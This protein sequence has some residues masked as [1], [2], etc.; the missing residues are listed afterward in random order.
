MA[1]NKI[2]LALGT[3]LLVAFSGTA[4]PSSPPPRLLELSKLPLFLSGVVVPN[5]FITM[6]DSAS[7]KSAYI[8]GS[9]DSRTQMAFAGGNSTT[10]PVVYRCGWQI[11]RMWSP[12]TNAMYYDPNRRY[13]PPLK[14]DGTPFPN[15]DFNAAWIDG[16]SANTGGRID[17]SHVVDLER[18]YHPTLELGIARS[19]WYALR[20][21][22]RVV[23][24]DNFVDNTSTSVTSSQCSF[25]DPEGPGQTGGAVTGPGNT[26]PATPGETKPPRFRHPNIHTNPDGTREYRPFYYRYSPTYSHS[27]SNVIRERVTANYH[28]CT[29][30]DTGAPCITSPTAPA[31][32]RQNFANWYSYYRV[33]HLAM[34]SALSF[35]FAQNVAGVRMAWQVQED[36]RDPRDYGPDAWIQ[37][38]QTVMRSFDDEQTKQ[39]FFNFLFSFRLLGQTPTRAATV[40]VGEFVKETGIYEDNRNPF[41]DDKADK[42]LSCRANYHLIVTDGYWNEPSISM[43]VQHDRSDLGSLPLPEGWSGG[44]Y[45]AYSYGPSN[46]GLEHRIYWNEPSTGGERPTLADLAFHYWSTDLRLDLPNNVP[47]RWS[48]LSTGVT[49]SATAPVTG[50]EAVAVPEVFFNPK[51]N[52]ARHQHLITFAIAF[53]EST[54]TLTWPDS[55]L[56]LRKGNKTWPSVSNSST[57]GI[58]DLWH[59]T[60]NSRGGYFSAA[61][62][63]GLQDGLGQFLDVVYEQRGVS[64]AATVSSGIATSR[65]LAFRAG[66]D[67]TDWSGFVEA[68]RYKSDGTLQTPAVWRAQDKL[69]DGDP[70][71]GERVIITS[72]NADGTGIPFRWGELPSEYKD[73]LNDDPTTLALDDDGHG[74]K[75]VGFLRGERNYE[76][77]KPGGLFRIR[78]NLLGAVA[79]A[80]SAMVGAPAS[81]YSDTGWPAGSPERVAAASPGGRYSDFVKEHRNRERRL[82]VGANDGMLHAFDA[83]TYDPENPG[84]GREKW[85]FIPRKVARNLNQLTRRGVAF[86]P[87]VDAS[88]AV[89]D[90]FHATRGWRTVLV[91]GLRRGG[92]G[93]FALDITDPSPSEADA[94]TFVL[95]EFSDDVSGAENLGFSYGAP[96]ISRMHH[97][98]WAAVLPGGYNSHDPA[99]APTGN[100][101]ATLY[102]VDISDGSLTRKIAI[103]ESTGLGPVTMGDYEGD[104]IDDFAVAGDLEGNVWYFDLK[105]SNPDNWSHFKLFEG[106]DEQPITSAPRIFGDTATG[107]AMVTFGTG[108]LI[109]TDDAADLSTQSFYA[110]RV[111]GGSYPIARSDLAERTLASFTASGKEYFTIGGTLPG[112]SHRGWFMDLTKDGERIT[113]T[114]GAHFSSGGVLISSIIPNG[115]DPCRGGLRGNFYVISASTGTT[116]AAQGIVP[117]VTS[118]DGDP[119]IGVELDETVPGGTPPMVEKPGGGGAKLPDYEGIEVPTPTWRRRNHEVLQ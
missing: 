96:N 6:D 24:D 88:V 5:V 101:E 108:K 36:Q 76:A 99:Y 22:N 26:A 2:I 70:S 7:M 13:E 55:Y 20:N 18:D 45:P 115:G 17:A 67:T 32:Q 64:A 82:I 40:R 51:N 85:A 48:D 61:D 42:E 19:T 33:R 57:A 73:W 47:P 92:Q 58:D 91:G 54:G 119:V 106:S 10:S 29:L 16:I 111:D 72:K 90:V 44:T 117:G 113:S 93:Y 37:P 84:T 114:P 71:P 68:Y 65:T 87:F 31:N 104:G 60:I 74:D 35:V 39:D 112:S 21:Y 62:T 52:P 8:P 66:Y 25:T 28:L 80:S 11:P 59:A 102:I 43:T 14:W 107:K 46:G 15:A 97:G 30:D 103:P 38:G 116:I 63:N 3:A 105:D 83:G 86:E 95:W 27:H 69:T 75:R 41:W 50:D 1:T 109:E 94:D 23:H 4:S 81:G 118:P 110:V 56:D 100:G 9:L 34:R 12:D 78:R 89:R 77:D 49:S 98:K 79:H 53:G